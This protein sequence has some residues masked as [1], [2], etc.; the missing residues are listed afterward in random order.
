[1]ASHSLADFVHFINQQIEIQRQMEVHLWSLD[2]LLT[3]CLVTSNF[4]DISENS[5]H[6]YFSVVSDLIQDTLRMNQTSLSHLMTQP[7]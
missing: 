1:M 7:R 5:L 2:A 6:H 4:Y 3:V